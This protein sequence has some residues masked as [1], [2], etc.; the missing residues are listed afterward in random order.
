MKSAERKPALEDLEDVLEPRRINT[1][2]HDLATK[3][4]KSF[5][6]NTNDVL[7]V[8][9]SG[10]AT[11]LHIITQSLE[12]QK[13]ETTSDIKKV[14]IIESIAVIKDMN[15]LLSGNHQV[16]TDMKEGR[17]YWG[18]PQ[19]TRRDGTALASWIVEESKRVVEDLQQNVFAKP[20][21][22][23]SGTGAKLSTSQNLHK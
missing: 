19:E 8:I 20:S 3:M 14:K 6:N 12:N 7:D 1:L 4:Y 17:K 16:V 5:R 22:S 2:T 21:T 10:D 23:T 11:K 15:N 18:Y 9:K 13:S